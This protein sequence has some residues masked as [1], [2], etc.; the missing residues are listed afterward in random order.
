[1]FQQK[2]VYI[3]LTA[4]PL[5]AG[6]GVHFADQSLNSLPLP[7]DFKCRTAIKN[8]VDYRYNPQDN[9]GLLITPKPD[10]EYET[11]GRPILT[12]G[13]TPQLDIFKDS[14]VYQGKVDQ[15]A[16]LQG[17]Y[18]AFAAGLQANQ[19]AS[20]NIFD[21]SHAYVLP[22]QIPDEALFALAAKPTTTPRYWIEQMYISGVTRTV[23]ESES[24]NASGSAEAFGAKGSVYQQASN[25]S[26]DWIVAVQLLNVDRYA[27]SLSG[28]IASSCI[29]V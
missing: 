25:A 12:Q 24:A 2:S 17:S 8:S 9:I 20:V 28:N 19:V 5:L 18:L 4:A 29:A 22:N 6:C 27:Q 13:T 26:N 16:S 21:V 11:I 10:G 15:G 23:F 3:V 7:E 14:N 1:M